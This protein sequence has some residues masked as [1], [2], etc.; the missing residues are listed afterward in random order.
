M[1]KNMSRRAPV[2]RIMRQVSLMKFFSKTSWGAA[3]VA[4]GIWRLAY[5]PATA[6]PTT[7]QAMKPAPF[8]DRTINPPAMVPSR[9][10]RKVPASTK[11]LPPISSS[12]ARWSGRMAYFT[13]PKNADWLPIKNRTNNRCQTSPDKR[14]PAPSIMTPISANLIRRIRKDFSIL[15]ANCP[16]RAEKRKNGS[17][18]RP[19]AMVTSICGLCPLEAAMR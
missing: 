3:A 1:D 13:G 19:A 4:K 10:A 8:S 11:A 2:N 7:V 6:R 15:S 12:L 16:A 5:Q 14:P 17:M 9:M 18:N